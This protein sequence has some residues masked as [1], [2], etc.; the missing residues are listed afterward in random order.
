M[1][2]SASCNTSIYSVNKNAHGLLLLYIS[3][4]QVQLHSYTFQQIEIE[5][6]E[7]HLRVW[8]KPNV[9]LVVLY[10]LWNVKMFFRKCKMRCIVLTINT[11]TFFYFFTKFFLNRDCSSYGDFAEKD[12]TCS[13]AVAQYIL[14]T[15]RCGYECLSF[16]SL[17]WK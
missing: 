4:Q 13:I 2:S 17:D 9:Y 15:G 12:E 7:F 5:C 10:F 14:S 6:A 11:A 1:R 8:C 16:G 3:R